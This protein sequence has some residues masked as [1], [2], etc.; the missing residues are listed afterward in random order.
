M[1]VR[2]NQL[3]RTCLRRLLKNRICTRTA[4]R[5]NFTLQFP[6]DKHLNLFF[7]SRIDYEPCVTRCV[8]QLLH[9]GDVA[10]DIGANIGYFTLLFS[11]IVGKD[12]RVYAFEPDPQN[13]PWLKRN[14]LKNQANNVL[15]E[16][17]AV[18]HN[19]GCGLLYQDLTT[20]RTS[21]LLQESWSPDGKKRN[22]VEVQ[23]VTLDG[24]CSN[25]DQVDM[26]KID[27]EGFEK[28]V[29]DGG[30]QFFSELKPI[31][32]I[33]ISELHRKY[34]F[35][36]FDQLNYQAFSPVS[37]RKLEPEECLHNVLFCPVERIEKCFR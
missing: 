32:L 23:I 33:E 2:D 22:A 27:T 10:I 7:A 14:V 31:V 36:F 29:V 13:I 20:T 37:S 9:K 19:E 24:F 30:K 12:G 1:G 4:R 17:K 15:I 35:D 21:S 34:I 25:V 8:K 3:L 16:P 5:G 11:E 18:G 26:V 6:A 28:D